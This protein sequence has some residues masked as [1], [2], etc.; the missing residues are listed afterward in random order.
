MGQQW[1]RNKAGLT[2]K[3][4]T[5]LTYE[6]ARTMMHKRK[7][8]N[9]KAYHE[10]HKLYRPQF[11]PSRPDRVYK[12]DFVG[13]NDFL[14]NN[15]VFDKTDPNVYLPFWDAARAV[16]KLG[17]DTA[18]EWRAYVK[19]NEL[20]NGVPKCPEY[21]YR[22]MW[23]KG[24]GWREWLGQD[25]NS[26]MAVTKNVTDSHVWA[27]IHRPEFPMNVMT[28]I[29]ESKSVVQQK[30]IAGRFR[31]VAM[32]EYEKEME[33][34]LWDI[35]NMHS[36]SYYGEAGDRLCSNASQLVADLQHEL[37]MVRS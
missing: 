8:P 17:I 22:D 34:R 23:H 1:G 33:P 30:S 15:N 13:W 12:E 36:T 7:I 9:K 14:G 29:K 18:R 6:E 20:P 3:Q 32:F 31:L 11:V 10:W 16:H 28:I 24:V 27:L 25:V 5:W 37:L 19:E 4:R 26:V 35:M 2:G 21:V